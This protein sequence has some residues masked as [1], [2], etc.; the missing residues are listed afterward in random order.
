VAFDP[1]DRLIDVSEVAEILGVH[2]ITIHKWI[3]STDK[4]RRPEF[5]QPI[6]TMGQRL[7]WRRSAIHKFIESHEQRSRGA[8]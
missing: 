6:R 3:S 4:R 8:A 7:K 5:P 1:N 2:R